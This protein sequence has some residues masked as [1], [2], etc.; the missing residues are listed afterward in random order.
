MLRLFVCL[1]LAGLLCCSNQEP[2]S[3]LIFGAASTVNALE[4]IAG[5]YYQQTGVVVRTSFAASSTLARQI[6][7]GAAADLFLSANGAWMTF[8]SEKNLIQ[9]DSQINLLGNQLVLAARADLEIPPE[10]DSQQVRN[11]IGHSSLAMGD[12][13]HVP[14]GQYALQSL[15]YLGWSSLLT[16]MQIH[17]ADVRK[18]VQMADLGEVDLVIAYES[19]IVGTGLKVIFHFPPE[20]HQPISYP[21]ARTKTPSATAD[22]FYQYLQSEKAGEV[23]RRHGFSTLEIPAKKERAG[24]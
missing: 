11:L 23:F 15:D 10:Q 24:E 12:P 3:V 16:G 21:L 18:A 14:A 13:E 9:V 19:D 17:A 5:D 1:T 22:A 20:S 6:D 8:L 4:E 7:A 2:A